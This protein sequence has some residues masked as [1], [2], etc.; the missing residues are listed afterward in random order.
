MNSCLISFEGQDASG[1]STLMRS[2][3]NTLSRK[4]CRTIV[5]DEFSNSVIG[6]YIKK[7]LGE[8]KFIRFEEDTPTAFTET[9]YL[10]A[11]LY[12]QDE[13]EIRPALKEGTI[14]LKER[15]IDTLYSC[16]IP[17]IMNDYPEL[18]FENIYNW[19]KDIICNLY[20][21]DKTFLLTVPKDIQIERILNRGEE[22][23]DEDLSVF[24]RRD[25]I[26]EKLYNENKDRITIFDNNKPLDQA[27]Q[28]IS[29]I[30]IDI[31]QDQGAI[32][33]RN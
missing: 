11:D 31:C 3:Y 12:Y 13:E 6:K 22:V 19:I 8:N 26:Y 21:P 1:K 25:S 29:D 4:G 2:V 17:K 30:I 28:E 32:C 18:E 5:V 20:V 9:M 24:K 14:V 16:Q 15:H 27:A 23:S 10:T 7:L 33:G